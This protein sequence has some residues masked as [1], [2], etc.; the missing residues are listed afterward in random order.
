MGLA[1]QRIRRRQ[2][3]NVWRMVL[4]ARVE[5]EQSLGQEAEQFAESARHGNL[6]AGALDKKDSR[7]IN[8]VA[9][10]FIDFYMLKGHSCYTE[11]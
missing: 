2:T 10:Q 11:T 5:D 7:K 9:H 1:A 6:R 3:Q 8:C 4:K